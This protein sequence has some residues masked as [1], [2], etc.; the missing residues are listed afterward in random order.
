MPHTAP[1]SFPSWVPD[2]SVDEKPFPIILSRERL[3]PSKESPVIFSFGLELSLNLRGRV[4]DRIQEPSGG[5][6][7]K[8]LL[9]G[10]RGPYNKTI[11]KEFCR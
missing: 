3:Q 4:V 5:M 10:P 6:L 7:E 1:G 11:I 2:F 9:F 8:V